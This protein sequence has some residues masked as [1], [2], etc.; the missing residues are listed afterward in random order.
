M[1]VTSRCIAD[2]TTKTG[3][4]TNLLGILPVNN[5]FVCDLI[6]GVIMAAVASSV[7]LFEQQR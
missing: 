5:L 3:G 4:V 7:V 2:D 6:V 1:F